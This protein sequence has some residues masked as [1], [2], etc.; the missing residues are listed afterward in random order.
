MATAV[1]ATGYGGPE[2]LAVGEVEPREPGPGEVVLE[3]RAAGVNPIDVKLYSG[4]FGTD[5][6]KLPMRLGNEAAGVVQAVGPDAVGPAGPVRVGDE[7]IAFRAPG[8]YTDRLVVPASAVVPKPAGLGWEQAAGLMLTGGTAVHAL[9]VVRPTAG[10]T[11]LLHGAAGGVGLMVVQLAVARGVRVV[12]TAAPANHDLLRDLGAVPVAYGEGS[13]KRVR[14]AAPDGIDAAIDTVGTAEAV[15]VSV[16]LVSDRGRIVTIAAFEYGAEQGI[17]RIGG[18]P[19]ADP[20][21]E[22]RDAARLD[23]ARLAGEKALTVQLAAT[24]GLR[25]AAAAHRALT[26]RHAPGKIVLIP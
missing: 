2:N 5:P 13:L 24:F 20:G 6:A 16:A 19:G 14:A 18:G 12:G 11:L 1:V 3:V 17:V 7:V 8:A 26:G 21:T 25:E 15:D 4:A 22:L 23:L 10:E 9:T